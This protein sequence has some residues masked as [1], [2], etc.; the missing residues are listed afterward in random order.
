MRVRAL[1]VAIAIVISAVAPARSR[2]ER[3]RSVRCGP[4]GRAR[5][6]S[7][8]SARPRRS[9]R[10]SRPGGPLRL[11]ASPILPADDLRAR[12]PEHDAP[13]S[14][15]HVVERLQ[16]VAVAQRVRASMALLKV[17][18]LSSR[19]ARVTDPLLDQETLVRGG[20]GWLFSRGWPPVEC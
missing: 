5:L 9:V 1:V 8:T 14:T 7:S 15:L 12:G 16:P 3:R 20:R 6:C 2:K 13:A 4:S 10:S 11:R 19:A 18:V 17:R